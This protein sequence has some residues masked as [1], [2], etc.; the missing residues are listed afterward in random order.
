LQKCEAAARVTGS[1]QNEKL[2]LRHKVGERV[3]GIAAKDK[4]TGGALAR[5]L[6][7]GTERW[8]KAER[9][10]GYAPMAGELNV[11][12][13][14][15]QALR[16]G[17]RVF[18][19]RFVGGKPLKRFSDAASPSTL[20][21]QGVNETSPENR[22]AHHSHEP[23]I[24]KEEGEEAHGPKGATDPVQADAKHG[25]SRGFYVACEIKDPE[26]DLLVGR[27]GIREP[28]TWCGEIELNRLDFT[29][30]PGVAFDLQGRRLGRGKGFYDQ[31][32]AAVRGTTCGVAF[33]EQ[34]VGEVPVEP[35]DTR[36]N[37]ILTPTRWIEL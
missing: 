20:L 33:D 21:K 9:I 3:R 7:A 23:P 10:L 29:L 11:W 16:E 15:L 4:G 26:K 12:P 13:L 32:L 18:L 8:K 30:V 36:V 17:K 14:L 19:P 6:L 31:M 35:H 2:V 34:I 22:C 37:C 25:G 24:E 28:E 5:A 1:I 27:F